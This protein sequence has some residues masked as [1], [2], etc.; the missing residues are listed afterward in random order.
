MLTPFSVVEVGR[1]S[2]FLCMYRLFQKNHGRWE[3]LVCLGQQGQWIGKALRALKCTNNKQL[4]FSSSYP[5]KCSPGILLL[6]LLWVVRKVV[7][8]W[9]QQCPHPYSVK[10]QEMNQHQHWITM[11]AKDHI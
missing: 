7:R 3:E 8:R 2:E 6:N 9:K 1:V 11:K 5:S 10:T 4:L